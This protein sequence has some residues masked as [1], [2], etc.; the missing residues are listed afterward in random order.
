MEKPTQQ[1]TR[2]P[3]GV[4]GRR[5]AGSVGVWR[6]EGREGTVRGTEGWVRGKA[7]T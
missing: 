3:L 1:R 5:G 2:E 4:R 6:G 7:K